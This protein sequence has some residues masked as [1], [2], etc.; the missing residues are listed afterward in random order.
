M[1]ESGKSWLENWFLIGTFRAWQGF[2]IFYI[3]SKSISAFSILWQLEI[4]LF[5]FNLN[6][7][8]HPEL[9]FALILTSL[10]FKTYHMSIFTPTLKKNLNHFIVEI[11]S[12]LNFRVRNLDFDPKVELTKHWKK[13]KKSIWTFFERIFEFF[14]FKFFAIL[15]IQNLSFFP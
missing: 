13:R 3:L 12:D 11:I 10:Y 6:F 5:R 4:C 14:F 7:R 15:K 1:R 8:V 9:S 2:G